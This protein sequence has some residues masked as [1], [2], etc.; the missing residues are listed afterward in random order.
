M[1]EPDDL[2]SRA[3]Q[4]RRTEARILAAAS[5]LF[6]EAGYERT[7]IRGIAR[8]AGVDAGLVMHY[9]GSK[10]QLFQRVTH[11][12]PPQELAGTPEEVSEQIL[13]RLADSLAT[14]PVHSL[15]M[16]RSMLTHPEAAEAVRAGAAQYRAQI[17]RSIPASDAG[18]RAEL[19]SA[20]ILGVVV[21][22][23]L[24]KSGGLTGVD[25]DHIIDLLRPCLCSLTRAGQD[26]R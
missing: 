13:A 4:R 15:A 23:H 3:E 18:L 22:R 26:R 9:F 11:G 2:P 8:A 5:G 16:L 10:Q 25:P 17:S 24:L 7:T 1:T 21:S 12:S 14:E 19:V 20:V 6:V